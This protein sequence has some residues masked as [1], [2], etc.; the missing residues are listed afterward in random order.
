MTQVLDT[1]G[2]PLVDGKW[3]CIGFELFSMVDEPRMDWGQI[4]Q[5]ADGRWFDDDEN[6]VTGILDPELQMM[7]SPSGADALACQS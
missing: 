6:E 7:V 3:Y 1:N 5:Y 4:L 2:K